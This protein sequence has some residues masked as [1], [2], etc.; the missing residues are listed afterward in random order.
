MNERRKVECESQSKK[1]WTF[2]T[3]SGR[4]FLFLILKI[5][6]ARS[7]SHRIMSNVPSKNSDYIGKSSAHSPE[8]PWYI[9]SP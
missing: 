2:D 7:I 3:S 9:A 8:V 1:S 4:P 5:G 6:Y